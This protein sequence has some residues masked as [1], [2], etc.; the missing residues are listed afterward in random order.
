MKDVFK[1]IFFGLCKG[2]VNLNFDVSDFKFAS[3]VMGKKSKKNQFSEM[4]KKD[5]KII[6]KNLLVL[7]LIFYLQH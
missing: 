4:S 5:E 3:K 2:K 7:S 1:L 6:Y